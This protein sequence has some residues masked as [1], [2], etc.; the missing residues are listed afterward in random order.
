MGIGNQ[1]GLSSRV[2]LE[3]NRDEVLLSNKSEVMQMVQVRPVRS[4]TTV[5]EATVD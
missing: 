5:S 1:I 3:K 4:D 2:L